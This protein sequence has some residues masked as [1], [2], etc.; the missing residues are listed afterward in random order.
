MRQTLEELG[1]LF[2]KFGQALSTRPDILPTNVSVELCKLQDQVPPCSLE[3]VITTIESSLGKKIPDLFASFIETPL[4]SASIA[5]VH[6]ATLHD[7]RSV[8]VKVL[9]PNI[10][11]AL[12]KDLRILHTLARWVERYWRDG[13]R[14]KPRQLIQ[15]FEQ[16]LFKELDFQQE[17]GNAAQLKRN[18]NNSPLLYVPEIYW[19]YVRDQ[20]LV[21]ERIYGI[22]VSDIGALNAQGINLKK[23][24]RKRP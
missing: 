20:V 17:A 8:V 12:E 4:A 19:D 13:K 23:T 16:N 24:L 7:G 15:E 3:H 11:E 10:R 9:R 1:P 6:A 2:I 5:Q 14:L 21:M 22:P 18:F